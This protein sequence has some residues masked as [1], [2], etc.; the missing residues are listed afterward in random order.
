MLPIRRNQFI[1]E[2][3]EALYRARK[4][5]GFSWKI[6]TKASGLGQRTIR[7]WETGDPKH[8]KEFLPSIATLSQVLHVYAAHKQAGKVE[9]DH[10]KLV[11]N[12]RRCD[13]QTK[14]FILLLAESLAN[15]I[16]QEKE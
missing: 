2:I 4:R 12:F 8:I 16:I 11:K 13:P 7:Q 14:R 10:E 9:K 3:R 15:D 1:T 6:I 5:S